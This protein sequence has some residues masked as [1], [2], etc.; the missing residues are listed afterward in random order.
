[1]Q[2]G[3]FAIVGLFFDTFIIV[4]MT[5]FVILSTGALDGVLTGSALT[6]RA[7][8]LGLGPIGNGFVAVC[9]LFFAFTTI[10][11]WYF[12]AEQNVKYLFGMRWLS[13]YRVLVLCFLMLG[14]FLHVTLVWELADLF[15]GLM[16][17]PNVIALIGLSKL[18]EKALKDYEQNFTTGGVP[19]FGANAPDG[20]RSQI[21]MRIR[22]RG[23]RP[24]ETEDDDDEDLEA[25]FG[26]RP[27]NTRR[28]VRFMNLRHHLRRRHPPKKK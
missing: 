8:T 23:D 24:F 10:V 6:Q 18:V 15:N 25:R 9:L 2:Q 17:I 12:F 7:F 1:M 22:V 21:P 27:V 28:L 20:G 3:L 19:L 13:T 14:S 16:V 26:K 11:G 4:N 5:A